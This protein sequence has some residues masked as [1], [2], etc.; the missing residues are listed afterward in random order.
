ML[1]RI[2]QLKTHSVDGKDQKIRL[3]A[4][5][6]M[7]KGNIRIQDYTTA[8]NGISKERQEILDNLSKYGGEVVGAGK[9]K[10]AGGTEIP[11][12]T[13]IDVINGS[14][15]FSPEWQTKL[16]EFPKADLSSAQIKS[17]TAIKPDPEN[18]ILR[19]NPEVYLSKRVFRTT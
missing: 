8:K 18:G 13:R 6:L 17:I 9:G 4:I 12:G 14:S 19:P 5:E 10:F 3:K 16:S 2:L 1:K 11:K 7:R 15:Q